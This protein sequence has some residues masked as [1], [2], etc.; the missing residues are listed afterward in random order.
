MEQKLSH[1]HRAESL[2]KASS[3]TEEEASALKKYKLKETYKVEVTEQL[4]RLDDDKLY[5]RL[6]MLYLLSLKEAE[7]RE[8]DQKT[9]EDRKEGTVYLPDLSKRLYY[10]KWKIIKLLGLEKLIASED[11]PKRLVDSEDPVVVNLAETCKL[12]K[13]DIKHY[14]NIKIADSWT[15]IQVVQHL[16]R[17]L[18]GVELISAGRPGTRGKQKRVYWT[19]EIPE[20]YQEIMTQWKNAAVSTDTN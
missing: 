19:A 3:K 10:L 9:L 17:S 15:N 7:V 1:I 20:L 6:K 18:L 8:I 14:L 12:L 2:D 16:L 4:V 13:R 5:P 11:S